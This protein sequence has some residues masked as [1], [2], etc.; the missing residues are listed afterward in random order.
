M[1]GNGMATLTLPIEAS[2]PTTEQ[3]FSITVPSGGGVAIRAY[4]DGTN[5][6]SGLGGIGVRGDAGGIG[7]G[8]FGEGDIGVVAVG[9]STGLMGSGPT[10][11]SGEGDIGVSGVSKASAPGIG[12]R[13]LGKGGGRGGWFQSERSAQVRLAPINVPGTTFT[14]QVVSSSEV[15][16]LREK[17]TLLPKGGLGGDLL[18][19]RD[20]KG[21]CTLW[22]CEQSQGATPAQWAPV[23]LGTRVTGLG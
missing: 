15:A 5:P 23:L 10:G 13:G 1:E 12:V 3:A 11:V 6:E 16:D 7:T 4:A 22:F 17:A 18:V 19:L 9:R 2:F 21:K 8:V 20:N 14:P